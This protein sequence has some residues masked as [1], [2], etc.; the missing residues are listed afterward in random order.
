LIQGSGGGGAAYGQLDDCL[1]ASNT[2]PGFGGGTYWAI[3]NRCVLSNNA[4]GYGGGAYFGAVNHSLLS[5]NRALSFGGGACSNTLNNCVLRNNY[6]RDG[7]GAYGVALLNCTVVSNTA[8]ADSGGLRAGTATNSILYYNLSGSVGSN[9]LYSTLSYCDTVPAAP[10]IGN[11]TNEPLFLDLAGGNFHLQT[12]SPCINSG[13]NS[14]VIGATDFDGNPRI[15]GGTVDIGAYEFPSPTSI[16]SYAWAQQFG[17]PTDGSADHSDTDADGL[18][19]W[20][21]WIAGTIPTNGA[22]VLLLNVPSNSLSGVTITWQ[23]VS[24]KI[25]FIERAAD[26]FAQPAF[27]TLQSNIVGQAGTTSYTDP[28]GTGGGPFFYRVGV[29]P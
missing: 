24:G 15:A 12:N 4:A 13:N 14:S 22:S 7:G 6:A 29:Q 28:D 8:M 9:Y 2:V 3:L 10:G 17:L 18:D 20:Q 16:L 1:V 25:Y 5:S 27:S 26:L 23:S 19:N 11:M 21:E